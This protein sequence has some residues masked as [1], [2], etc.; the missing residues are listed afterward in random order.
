MSKAA[1]TFRKAVRPSNNKYQVSVYLRTEEAE[2]VK[3]ISL[4]NNLTVSSVVANLVKEGLVQEKY[5][6]A[7]RA[8]QQFKEATK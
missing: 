3:A 1:G 4:A 6:G 2:A 5:Q 8:Y 7:I